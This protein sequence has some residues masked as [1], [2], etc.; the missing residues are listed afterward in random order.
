MKER[1]SLDSRPLMATVV[2]IAIV[3]VL[4]LTSSAA[5]SRNDAASMAAKPELAAGSEYFAAPSGSPSGEGS[6]AD[7]WD[8]QTALSHPAVVQPGDTIWLRDGIYTGLYTSSLNGKEG[9][10]II[11][12]SF[13]GES[14]VIDTQARSTDQNAFV[15]R[16]HWT[17]YWDFELMNSRLLD[18]GGG[19]E[20]AG[21]RNNKLINLVIHDMA[22]SNSF[23]DSNEIYGTVLY[24][25]GVDGASGHQLYV[26]NDDASQPARIVDSIIFNGFAFGIHAY[27]DGVGQLN[28]IHMIGN[29]WFNS[30]AAQSIGNR[31]DNVLVG[32]VNGSSNILLQENMGWAFSPSERSVSLGRYTD[33]N[34]DVTLIDNYLVGDTRFYNTWQSVMMRGNTFYGMSPGE[35][36]NFDPTQFPD[37]VYLTARPTGAQIFIRPN[38]YEQGRAHIVVYN[39]D[40]VSTVNVD[41]NDLLVPGDEY[42]VRNAQNYFSPPVVS[43]IY[44]GGHVPLP[45]TGLEPAQPIG[46]GRIEPLEYS[47]PEFNVFVILK[48]GDILDPPTVTPTATIMPSPTYSSFFPVF[49]N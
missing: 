20:F 19:I 46:W 49:V 47:G 4:A 27:A 18:R 36:T 31:K 30:G 38:Q 11:L 13:P 45:M 15:I 33:L 41:L 9:S 48:T 23:G 40:L 10:P 16:G 24:N 1:L 3:V 5:G 6:L 17:Y 39:W 37:N 35:G 29:V 44:S 34:Q 42:E 7:P 14:A 21:G 2:T 26:Q 12:R 43:G 8:L 25:N 22:R 28:G 32:G